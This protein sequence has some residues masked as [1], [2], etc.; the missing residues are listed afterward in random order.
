MLFVVMWSH[1]AY[2]T[3]GSRWLTPMFV[4]VQYVVQNLRLLRWPWTLTVG[5]E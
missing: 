1:M 5:E 2:L 3:R 4:F